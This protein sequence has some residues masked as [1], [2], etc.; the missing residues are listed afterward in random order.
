MKRNSVKVCRLHVMAALSGL[1]LSCAAEQPTPAQVKIQVQARHQNSLGVVAMDQHNYVRGLQQFDAAIALDPAY[2]TA[3]ANLGIARYSLGQYDSAAVDLQAA[4]QLDAGNL[5][6]AYTLGLIRH[7]QGRDHEVALRLFQQVAQRDDDD[8]L[9]RYYL[10]RTW[11]KLGQL[12]SAMASYRRVISLDGNNVSAWYA[13]AQSQR[14]AGDMESWKN[15][16]EVFNRLSQSGLDGVSSA[17]Q[18]QGKYAEAVAD[19]PFRRIGSSRDSTPA[20]AMEPPPAGLSATA[21]YLAAV[22]ADRDGRVDLLTQGTDGQPVLLHNLGSQFEASG[23]WTYDRTAVS[24]RARVALADVDADGDIDAAWMS[25]EAAITRQDSGLFHAMGA[26]LP[27]CVGAVFGDADHDGD[28][29]MFCDRGDR[30]LWYNDGVGT[31]DDVTESAGVRGPRVVQAIFSDLDTDRDVD[32]V[33]GGA[34]GVALLSNNRDGTFTDMAAD[35]GLAVKDVRAMAVADFEAD[36]AMDLAISSGTGGSLLINRGQ[37]TA[38]A[39]DLFPSTG[40][41]AADLDNDGD[42]DLISHGDQGIYAVVSGESGRESTQ[43]SPTSTDL[44]RV[45]DTDGDGR[46]DLVAPSGLYRNRSANGGSVRIEVAGLSSNPDGFGTRVEVQTPGSR[47]VQEY[48]AGRGPALHFGIGDEPVEFVRVLWPSGVRQTELDSVG[49]GRLQIGEVNRKGTSCPILYAWD[50]D[51]FEFVSDFLGGGIIGYLVAP[52]QYFTPDTD[53]YLPVRRLVPNDD[54]QYVLQVGNQLEEVIYLDGAELVAIDHPV[55]TELFP[56]ERLLT[57]PPYPPLQAYPVGSTRPL[58]RVTDQQGRDVTARLAAV[59]DD[60]YQDFDHTPVHGY[61]RSHSLTLDLGDLPAGDHPVLIAHGWVDYA[62]SSSNWAAAQQGLSLSPPRLEARVGS[63]PWRLV[64]AD[65]GVPAGLPKQM[66]VD[67]AGVFDPAATGAQLR[68]T[69]NTT[70]YWDQFLLGQV[71]P[72]APT[73]VHRRP[74]T[75]ADLHWRGYPTHESIHGTFAYRYDYDDVQPDA[76]WGTHAGAFTRYGDVG[77]LVQDVDDRFVVMFHGDE[78]TLE[79]A[80]DSFPPVEPGLSRTFLFYAD[81]FGKDM[82][83]HS[84]HS[85]TVGP[86]PFHGMSRYPYGPDENYPTTAEHVDYVLDYNTRWIKG[87]YR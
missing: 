60:W 27:G 46:L 30:A 64:Q 37:F 24:G 22:D 63:G 81:G 28:A 69:T 66:L 65:M 44:L 1:I 5:H 52:G 2:A 35:R 3:H 21:T 41:V 85:K 54:D 15:T 68:I 76:G 83:Y 12:D 38:E 53:E 61:A 47:Q 6:A 39:L 78:L 11:A 7:A 70:V 19:T 9:V 31:F 75:G 42:V 36:G 10:G 82:D 32:I 23:L 26:A 55:G 59:D 51:S 79:V 33:A 77:P 16:L 72:N 48:R 40:L 80:A 20:F 34:F 17:Y 45:V 58:P 4:L 13:L 84:A 86:L 25:T 8:P 57:A 87:Y 43:I 73:R 74:F 18:G 56:A 50:G 71:V 49:A 14:Q 29:D 62:H 67:L